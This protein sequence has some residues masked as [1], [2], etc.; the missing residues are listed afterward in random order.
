MAVSPNTRRESG[1]IRPDVAIPDFD[2]IIGEQAWRSRAAC[3]GTDPDM[4]FKALG[5]NY[6]HGPDLMKICLTCPVR[7]ECENWILNEVGTKSDPAGF[8]AGMTPKQRARIR[9]ER[10]RARRAS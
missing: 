3:R 4:W 5:Q 8:T 7:P 10:N 9:R 1:S 2:F 6:R